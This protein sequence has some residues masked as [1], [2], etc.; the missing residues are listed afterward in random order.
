MALAWAGRSDL[1][2]DRRRVSHRPSEH[3]Y[4][5]GEA[6]PCAILI[7]VM[8]TRVAKPPKTSFGQFAR[9]NL[10]S[11]FLNLPSFGNPKGGA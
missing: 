2:R 5:L 11:G 7:S 1:G 6:G 9:A 8:A 4:V 10:H 3:R